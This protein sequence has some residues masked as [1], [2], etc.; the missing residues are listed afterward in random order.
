MNC[1]ICNRNFEENELTEHHLYPKKI[2]KRAAFK[3]IPKKILQNSKIT[4]CRDCHKFLHRKF[5]HLELAEKLSSL[6]KILINSVVKEYSRW[7]KTQS[8][9]IK[10]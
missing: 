5:S 9:K 4:I 6:S 3:K 1:P 2:W 7:A 10:F 8:K